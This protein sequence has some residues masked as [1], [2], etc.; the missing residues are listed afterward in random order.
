MDRRLFIYLMSGR[1][2]KKKAILYKGDKSQ[3]GE[4]QESDCKEDFIA[5]V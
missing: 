5:L 1:G 4:N 3:T 2:K